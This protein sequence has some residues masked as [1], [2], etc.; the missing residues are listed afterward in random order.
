MTCVQSSMWAAGVVANGLGLM[1]TGSTG[2]GV[3]DTGLVNVGWMGMRLGLTDGVVF[4]LLGTGFTNVMRM[5]SVGLMSVVGSG[6]GSSGM[7][8]IGMALLSVTWA[9][10]TCTGSIGTESTSMGWT[11]SPHRLGSTG[12]VDSGSGSTRPFSP[13][14]RY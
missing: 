1:R 5:G 12:A 3:V 6:S 2:T 4:K 8:I 14:I 11:V 13:N 10:S 7:G 9:G